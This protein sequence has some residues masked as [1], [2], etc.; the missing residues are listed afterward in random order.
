[1]E[2]DAALTAAGHTGDPVDSGILFRIAAQLLFEHATWF[3]ASADLQVLTP[4]DPRHEFILGDAPAVTV[5]S[6]Q[7]TERVGVPLELAEVV[8]MPLGPRHVAALGSQHGYLPV[9]GRI[10]SAVNFAQAVH[11]VEFVFTRPGSPV[12]QQLLDEHR[13]RRSAARSAATP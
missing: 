9:D 12:F 10:V 4:R 7:L 2:V 8:V 1:M 13:L 3:T 5:G 11:A 6:R